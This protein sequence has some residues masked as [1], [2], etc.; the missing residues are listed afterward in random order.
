MYEI[1]PPERRW[2]LDVEALAQALLGSADRGEQAALSMLFRD[3]L[4]TFSRED[5]RENYVIDLD[6]GAVRFDWPE[7]AECAAVGGWVWLSQGARALLQLACSIASVECPVRLG[8][9]L[10]NLDS[11]N[12]QAFLDAV[13]F[14]AG[15]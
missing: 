13:A 6:D 7:L 2:H 14:A 8:D 11:G 1:L 15:R 9:A 5:I 4:L 3:P 10:G 12:R